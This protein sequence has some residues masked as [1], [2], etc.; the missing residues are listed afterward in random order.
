MYKKARMNY[1]HLKHVIEV[2]GK[3]N[4]YLFE[5]HDDLDDNQ[6]MRDDGVR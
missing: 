5:L 6:V 1:E 3:Y 4:R 2:A